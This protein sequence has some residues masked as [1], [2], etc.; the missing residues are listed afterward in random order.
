MRHAPRPRELRLPPRAM[1]A[2]AASG[3]LLA[4]AV[5]GW[6]PAWLACWILVASACSFALY[7]RDKRAAQHAGRRTPERTLQLLSFAGGWPGALLAQ[8]LLRHKNRKA[9]FQQAFWLC[10]VANIGALLVL[11]R[12]P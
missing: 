8:A 10:V 5:V 1:L 4:C 2:L 9:S 6:I 12:S 3:M 7:W 11:L